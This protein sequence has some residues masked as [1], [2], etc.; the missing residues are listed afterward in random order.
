MNTLQKHKK[1][2]RQIK[3]AVSF[4]MLSFLTKRQEQY[5]CAAARRLDR[6]D[7]EHLMQRKAA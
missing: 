4:T 2:V 7:R 1:H 3:Q 5:V 6:I